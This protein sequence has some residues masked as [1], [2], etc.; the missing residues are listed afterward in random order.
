MM[1][2]AA[3]LGL[4]ALLFLFLA[5]VLAVVSDGSLTLR[6]EQRLLRM[7]GASLTLAVLCGLGAIWLAVIGV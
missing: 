4:T 5:M 7:S 1:S 6:G 3:G 2:I